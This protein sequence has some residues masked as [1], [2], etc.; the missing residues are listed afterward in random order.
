VSKHTFIRGTLILTF[1]SFITRLLGFAFRV[2]MSNTMGAEGVGL[3]QLIFPIYMMIW[4]LSSAG[5]SVAVSKQVAELA[6][7]NLYNDCLR[8]LRCA[9]LLSLTIGIVISFILS[10]FAPI[11]ASSFIQEPN[12]TLSLRYL[13]LC[14]PFMTITTCIKGYFQ[15]RHQ[16]SVPAT[17]QVIEQV[18]RMAIIYFLGSFYIPKGLEYACALGTLGLCAGELCSFL[19]TVTV[20]FIQK[21]RLLLKAP[22]VSYLGLFS[23]LLGVALPLTGNRFLTSALSSIENILM[24]LQLQKYGLTASEALSQYGMFSGMALP[25]LLFPTMVTGSIS[26]VM[27]PTISE[28]VANRKTKVLQKTIGKT[29]HFAALIGIGATALFLTFGDEIGVVVFNFQELGSILRLLAIICP[30]LYLQNILTG[31]LNGLGLQRLTFQGNVLSSI[32]CISCIFLLVPQKGLVGFTL[33][34]LF[35]AGFATIYHLYNM[36]KNI[37][38]PI[39]VVGWILKPLICG[40]ITGLLSRYVHTHIFMSY[41]PLLWATLFSVATLGLCYLLCLFITRSLTKEDILLFIK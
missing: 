22:T 5:I 10:K 12:T 35:Q 1:A 14:I 17:T 31:A 24:P 11:I 40:L 23:S 19:F 6:A 30:F 9:I 8:L 21:R 41:F 7:R 26:T 25:L 15:G 28:A 18:A 27:V 32:L 36:L 16:M 37:D 34:L 33:A 13:A 4:S 29:I 38:L 39:D 3:Y 2:Y 20:F